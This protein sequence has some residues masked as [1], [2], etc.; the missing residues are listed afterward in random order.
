MRDA[1]KFR[2]RLAMKAVPTTRITGR[3]VEHAEVQLRKR[4]FVGPAA[5]N[6]FHFASIHMQ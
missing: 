6:I 5:E 2:G 1:W 3:D 4:A